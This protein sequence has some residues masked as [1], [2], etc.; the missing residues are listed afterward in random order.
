MAEDSLN[1]QL[2]IMMEK[3]ERSLL[4]AKSFLDK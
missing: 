2:K 1:E 4:A 3:A